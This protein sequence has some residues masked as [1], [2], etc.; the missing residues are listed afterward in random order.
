MYN[1]HKHINVP[2]WAKGLIRYFVIFNDRAPG[3]NLHFRNPEKLSEGEDIRV[4]FTLGNGFSH[5]R[6]M[7][8]Y[9]GVLLRK[10]WVPR[11]T[12]EATESTIG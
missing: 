11:V 10:D 12:R 7:V 9:Q 5:N 8:N 2:A 1:I 6:V 3:S 4:W